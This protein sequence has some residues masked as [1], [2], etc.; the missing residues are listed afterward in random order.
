MQFYFRPVIK[1]KKKFFYIFIYFLSSFIYFFQTQVKANAVVAYVDAPIDSSEIFI[2]CHNSED[3]QTI[4]KEK[5]LNHL[6]EAQLI[7]GQY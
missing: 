5:K 6:G 3:A 7:D 2:R 4:L 1:K